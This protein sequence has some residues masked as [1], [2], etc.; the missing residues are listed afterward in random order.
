MSPRVLARPFSIGMLAGRVKRCWITADTDL[1][2]GGGWRLAIGRGGRFQ[3]AFPVPQPTSI[4]E[5]SVGYASRSLVN[6]VAI[7]QFR[8]LDAGL[9]LVDRGQRTTA[10]RRAT[11]LDVGSWIAGRSELPRS[12]GR[13]ATARGDSAETRRLYIISDDGF[14]VGFWATL[15]GT[16]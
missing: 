13:A 3:D 12:G 5:L 2:R 10:C 8:F 7:F 4:D 1:L 9:G 16:E 6:K 15:R 11:I 14:Q